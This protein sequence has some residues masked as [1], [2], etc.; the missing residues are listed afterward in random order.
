MFLKKNT[1]IV[2]INI[3]VLIGILFCIEL[4]FKINKFY[5]FLS[6]FHTTPTMPPVKSLNTEQVKQKYGSNI[7][8]IPEEYRA[9]IDPRLNKFTLANVDQSSKI[10]PF[11]PYGKSD[12]ISVISTQ[13][14][15]L[16]PN[17]DII[18]Y[19]AD[20]KLYQDNLRV[21]ENQD[22]KKKTSKFILTMGDS[23][24]FGQ[25]VSTGKD[26]P[27]QLA[28]K[29]GNQWKI[30]NFARPGDGPN[31]TIFGLTTNPNYLSKVKESEGIVI[32]YFIDSHFERL[33]CTFLCYQTGEYQSYISNKPHF[34]FDGND[35]I[36]KG[37][38]LQSFDPKRKLQQLASSLET[39]KF[40]GIGL[41][42]TYTHEQV[43][44]L[45][46]SFL[47]IYTELKKHKKVT[48]F[49]LVFLDNTRSRPELIAAANKLGLAT[50][51]FSDITVNEN[52]KYPIDRHP[53]SEFYWILSEA[54]KSKIDLK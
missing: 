30:Y 49:Y 33:L 48:Q 35:F 27:S 17:Q 21:V 22:H 13:Y 31:D 12:E 15:L 51:D 41:A 42:D 7:N 38:F 37:S 26:Y 20:Y 24:T 14:H 6:T 54:L 32:W 18:I 25:G 50:L 10:T 4:F 3:L 19:A 46:K 16:P 52:A 47:K 39:I 40:S 53:T 28:K 9:N 44:I 23:F 11:Y 34:E 8:N 1:K 45:A 2:F 36:Y 43:E 29:I 5:N